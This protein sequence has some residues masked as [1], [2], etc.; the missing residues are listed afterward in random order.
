MNELIS[1]RFYVDGILKA[2]VYSEDDSVGV[3]AFLFKAYPNSTVELRI[4]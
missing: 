1:Y 3:A 4:I 2:I